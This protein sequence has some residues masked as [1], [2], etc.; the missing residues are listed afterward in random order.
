M[1]RFI[2]VKYI[3]VLL[4]YLLFCIIYLCVSIFYDDFIVH[5]FYMLV[6]HGYFVTDTKNLI[7]E[8]I[9][10]F[11]SLFYN[12]NIAEFSNTL[13][14][15]NLE[16]VITLFYRVSLNSTISEIPLILIPYIDFNANMV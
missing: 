15:Y 10:H 4:F 2:N 12:I 8:D 3:L 7:L 6:K 1:L 16:D 9:G 11:E 5:I 13:S 14:G